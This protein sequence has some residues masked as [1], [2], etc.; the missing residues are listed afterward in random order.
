MFNKKFALQAL[1]V[2]ALTASAG[3]SHATLTVYNSLAAFNADPTLRLPGTDTFAGFSITGSTPSPLLRTAGPYG[4][5]ATAVI[6]PATPSSSFFGAGTVADPW[7][8][9]NLA[10]DSIL[11][12]SFTGGTIK[13]IG[14]NFFGSDINGAF[15]AGDVTL[16]ATNSLGETST[17]TI[18]G[19]TV[20]SFLGFVT[21]GTSVITSLTL[22]AVSSGVLLWATA[23]NLVLAIPEPGTYALMLAGLAVVGAAARRR[24]A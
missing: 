2:A 13:G 18:T 20:G 17:Q 12:D 6:L 4:Y 1:V 7:L 5:T 10:S 23:D 16:T 21:S 11:F 9:L 8:S 22:S 14:G 24:K 19:A 15:L 3:A